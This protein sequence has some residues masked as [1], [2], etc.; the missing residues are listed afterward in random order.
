MYP[1]ASQNLHLDH[2]PWDIFLRIWSDVGLFQDRVKMDERG[3][4]CF[5]T[6]CYLVLDMQT[7]LSDLYR[8][9][10]DSK[11][12]GPGILVLTNRRPLGHLD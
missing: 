6:I 7:I 8:G 12:P 11:F 5:K 1:L 10:S 9:V 2:P 3:V 4:S